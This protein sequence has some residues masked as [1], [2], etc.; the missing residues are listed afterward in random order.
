MKK[1]ENQSTGKNKV[2]RMPKLT[3][4]RIS[5]SCKAKN[6]KFDLHDRKF[7]NGT[8]ENLF[9]LY[10]VSNYMRLSLKFSCK[11]FKVNSEVTWRSMLWFLL[12]ILRGK[13]KWIAW[14]GLTIWISL[15]KWQLMEL[16]NEI[17]FSFLCSNCLRKNAIFYCLFIF[18]QW[19]SPALFQL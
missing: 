16:A 14:F 2:I 9:N 4:N 10:E 7:L 8:P 11:T 3:K 1:K 15:S 12:V 13:F 19:V 5:V 17:L 18:V 6:P